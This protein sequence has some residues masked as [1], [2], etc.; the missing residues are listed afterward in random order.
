ME[1]ESLRRLCEQAASERD[2]GRLTELVKEIIQIFDAQRPRPKPDEM[3][4]AS[5]ES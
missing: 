3:T 5:A 2:G 4:E 1:S